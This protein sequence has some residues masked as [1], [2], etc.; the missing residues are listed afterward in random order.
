[1]NQDNFLVCRDGDVH[2]RAD[3][4]ESGLEQHDGH[5]VLIAVADGMGGHEDGD[6]AS[7]ASVR[8]LSRLYRRG[9]S[10]HP[11]SG[12]R[13]FVLR[14]HDRL[15]SR[16]AEHGPVNM[17]TTLTTAWVL[18]AHAFWSHVGD[19]RL[20]HIRGTTL[21]RVSRDHTRA[22]FARRDGLPD[23]AYPDFLAQTFLYGSRGL[24]SD[25][26]LRMDPALD[27]GRIRLE[28]GDW[29]LLCSD[30]LCGFLEDAVIMGVLRESSDPQQAADL[31][32]QRAMNS[33]S[34]DN[35][36]ILIAQV[37]ELDAAEFS[38]GPAPFEEA[39]ETTTALLFDT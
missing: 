14:A 20:Y 5:G 32:A 25:G 38:P 1:M 27:T 18:G 12:M 4:D 11:E 24:G 2:Y 8:A 30:G 22:E 6:I 26:D 35:I 29:M 16:A 9:P 34:D 31:L 19:S 13:E 36:T 15:R 3:G 28:P 23:P 33:D 7:A 10:S 21:I 39:A 17:G 37:D